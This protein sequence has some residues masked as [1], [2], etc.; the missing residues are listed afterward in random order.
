MITSYF[1]WLSAVLFCLISGI[2]TAQSDFTI[3]SEPEFSLNLDSPNR[4][5]FNFGIGNRNLM[6]EDEQGKF[7]ARH[8]ELSH[9]TSYEV[10]F[11]SK[12]SLGLRYRF[13]E[14]FED[15]QHDEI[16]ITQQYGRSKKFDLIKIAHRLRFEQRFREETSFRSRYEF[17]VE[18]PLNGER[19]DKNE[20]FMVTDTEALWSIG[21]EQ[22][23][24]FEHRVGISVGNEIFKDTTADVGLEYRLDDYNNHPASELFI[25]AGISLSI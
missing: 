14:V 18:F 5:S 9:F 4:W 12:L 10:G 15:S 8:L 25:T 21:K 16:R 13:R 17:S 7:D 2:S 20:F 11:Y 6:M 3:Y 22:K 19:V 1:K 24:S 23:P